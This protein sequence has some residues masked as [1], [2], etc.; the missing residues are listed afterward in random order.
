MV[1]L[2]GGTPDPAQLIETDPE[3]MRAAGLSY[4]KVAYLRDLAEHVED[5]RSTWSSC[6]SSPTRR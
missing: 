5:G 4:A 6:P 2:F 1:D 3:V